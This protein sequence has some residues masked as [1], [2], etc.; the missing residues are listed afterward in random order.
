[1]VADTLD[2]LFRKIKPVH[3]ENDNNKLQLDCH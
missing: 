2:D 1:M 3:L